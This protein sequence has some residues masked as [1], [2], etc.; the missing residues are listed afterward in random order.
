MWVKQLLISINSR[1]ITGTLK[2][3]V[4]GYFKINNF[5]IFFRDLSIPIIKKNRLDV[6][7]IKMSAFEIKQLREN[8]NDLPFEFFC[9]ESHGF[10]HCYVAFIGNNPAAIHW[11][12]VPGERSRFLHLKEGDV[13]LNYTVVLPRF[14]GKR[15]AEHLMEYIIHDA[16]RNNHKRIFCV[17][18]VSNIPQYKPMLRLGFLPV[19]CLTHFFIWRPKAKLNY[20]KQ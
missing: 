1:G 11:L 12:V 6:D 3:G 8:F 19:E 13:E 20:L 14:R 10:T 16:A 7:I 15:I 18:H 2:W 5:I 9:D 4:D 17:A